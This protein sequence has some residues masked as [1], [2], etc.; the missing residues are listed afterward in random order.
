MIESDVLR[1]RKEIRINLHTKTDRQTDRQT[2]TETEPRGKSEMNIKGNTT[3]QHTQAQTTQQHRHRQTETE[4]QTESDRLLS[5]TSP[6]CGGT[7]GGSLAYS[8][9]LGIRFPY[10]VFCLFSST[11]SSSDSGKERES[12][13]TGR[14]ISTR[15]GKGKKE[16]EKERMNG[17]AGKEKSNSEGEVDERGEEEKYELKLFIMFCEVAET[18]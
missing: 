12:S 13:K 14:V 16:R 11:S 4:R 5:K 8:S 10:E 1:Y 15:E 3:E 17:E 6:S 18:G 9:G 7:F 2:E